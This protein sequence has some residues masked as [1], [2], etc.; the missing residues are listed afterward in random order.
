[1]AHFDH[2]KYSG[3]WTYFLS[4][5]CRQVMLYNTS[6]PLLVMDQV[7][8]RVLIRNTVGE[9]TLFEDQIHWNLDGKYPREMSLKFPPWFKA[10]LI[11]KHCFVVKEFV[12]L[13]QS[14]ILLSDLIGLPEQLIAGPSNSIK[15]NRGLRLFKYL[16]VNYNVV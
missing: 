12:V 6:I 16:V 2:R 7:S 10:H 4:N 11:L 3:R 8:N 14:T 9:F 1:M 13:S 15:K 5:F